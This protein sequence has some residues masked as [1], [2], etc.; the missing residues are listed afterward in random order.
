MNIL[1]I[2]GNVSVAMTLTVTFGVLLAVVIITACY[3][4]YKLVSYLFDD[5]TLGG[6]CILTVTIVCGV[7]IIGAA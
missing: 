5:L 7:Y 2:A 3:G 1:E 6:W 4:L